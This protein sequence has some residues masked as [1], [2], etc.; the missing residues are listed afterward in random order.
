MD[1]CAAAQRGTKHVELGTRAFLQSKKAGDRLAAVD[2]ADG[3][4][5]EGSDA[6]GLNLWPCGLGHGVG[7]DDFLDLGVSEAL[8]G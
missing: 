1:F 4:A 7:G 8:V 3:F 6:D 2:S 5:E